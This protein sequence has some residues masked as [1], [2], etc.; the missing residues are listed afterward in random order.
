MKISRL[1]AAE[2]SRKYTFIFFFFFPKVDNL[3]L[4]WEVLVTKALGTGEARVRVPEHSRVH[5]PDY[6]AKQLGSN[7]F[8]K[9][10]KCKQS[11]PQ[12]KF[13]EFSSK[14]GI[15]VFHLAAK[16]ENSIVAQKWHSQR[17]T[18]LCDISM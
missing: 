12:H 11:Q 16:R 13:P 18:R 15:R 7:F 1:H 4:L 10:T 5:A 9:G 17:G 6:A 2:D 14:I 8:T 3:S